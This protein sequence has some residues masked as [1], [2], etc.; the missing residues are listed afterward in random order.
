MQIVE[1]SIAGVRSA[2]LRLR[3]HDTLLRF[4]IY[5]MV[6]V[7]EPAFYAAVTERL[8]GCDLIVT[9]GVDGDSIADKL[10][11]DALDEIHQ[12]RRHEPITVAVVYGA[13]HVAPVVHGMRA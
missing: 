2:V 12:R 9:E 11:I 1:V 8:R 3:R 7:G 4:L 13:A 6:H 5:P 10:L